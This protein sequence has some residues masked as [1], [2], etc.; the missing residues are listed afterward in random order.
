MT[1]VPGA[2]Y[3][4]SVFVGVHRCYGTAFIIF[5]DAAN[6]F[7]GAVSSTSNNLHEAEGGTMMYGYKRIGGFGVAPGNA[8]SCIIEMRKG[9]T[10]P[11]H[12]SSYGFFTMP[13]IAEA[14]ANQTVL[15]AWSPSGVGVQITPAG[16]STPSLSALTANVGLLR[17]APSGGRTEIESN[18]IRVYDG[19]NVLR[20]QMGVW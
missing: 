4:F 9:A 12:A 19:N 14:T 3:E 11:G 10:L 6:N 8:A 20:V 13:L 15:S 2:R 18:Q 1:V 17:T 16:I 5:Y 7:V